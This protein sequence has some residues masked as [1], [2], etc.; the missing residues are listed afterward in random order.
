MSLK[1][2]EQIR[3]GEGRPGG[4]GDQSLGPRSPPKA[5]RGCR[6]RSEMGRGP[7][8]PQGPEILCASLG[9]SIGESRIDV[10]RDTSR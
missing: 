1:G 4:P 10:N 8:S 7:V 9:Q 6:H 2:L 3:T 5:G